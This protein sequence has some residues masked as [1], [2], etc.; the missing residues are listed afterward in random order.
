MNFLVEAIIPYILLYKYWALFIITFLA[1]SMFP[2]P[3]GTLL[4]TSAAF[5]SQGYLNIT[6]L[7]IVVILANIIGDNVL[8]WFAR[9]YGEK[10][11]SKIGFTKRMLTSQNFILIKEKISRRPGFLIFLS[12]F[13]VIFTLTTNILC[14]ISRVHYRKFLK[15]EIIGTFANVFFYT[16]IGY[17]FGNSWQAVNDLIGNFSIFCFLIIVLIVSLSSKKIIKRLSKNV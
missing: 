13:E 10:I 4:I 9:L 8:Y 17:S 6:T 2:I 16:V 15:F 3:S 5:A 11:L 14:G 12:R 7:L 1:S